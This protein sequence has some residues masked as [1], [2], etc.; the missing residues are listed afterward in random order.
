M[1]PNRYHGELSAK[2][3]VIINTLHT[4]EHVSVPFPAD[5][6]G[7]SSYAPLP[8]DLMFQSME[9]A[10]ETAAFEFLYFGIDLK[11]LLFVYGKQLIFSEQG[12]GGLTDNGR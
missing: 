10:I 7:L 12:L 9:V 2:T 6:I 4:P 1:G 8:E 5:F 11:R 3:C